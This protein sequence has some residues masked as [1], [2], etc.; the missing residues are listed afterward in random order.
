MS[1]PS[2]AFSKL[3]GSRQSEGQYRRDKILNVL[4]KE[5]GSRGLMSLA[6]V[7]DDQGYPKRAEEAYQKVIEK[8]KETPEQK[9]EVLWFCQVK[10]SSILRQ[11]GRYVGAEDQCRSFLKLSTKATGP[12]SRLSLQTAGDL[13]LVLRDQ[14]KF[15]S[16]LTEIYRTLHNETCSPYQD[17]THVRL[18]TIFAIILRDFG[19]YDMSLFLIRNALRVSGALPDLGN[20][21]PFTLDLASELS[22]I[23]TERGIH[24]LAEE[25]AR[26][27][28]DGFA[29]TFGTD[30]PQSLKAASRLANAIRFN[31]RLEDAA[32]L[33]ERTLKAQ[34]LQLGSTHPD[35]IPTKCGLAAVYA[36][37]ARFR[38]SVS[39]LRA[40]LA[41]QNELLSQ[42]PHPDTDWTVQALG[43][44]RELQKALSSDST[45]ESEMVEESRRMKDFFKKPFRKDERS[46][47]L[48][49]ALTFSK[50]DTEDVRSPSDLQWLLSAH[51]VST[52]DRNLRS[53]SLDTGSV[54]GIY[55]T[56]LHVASFV[57]DLKLV[58]RLLES[59]MDINVKGGI[60]E[61]PLCAA[62]YRGHINIVTFLLEH[63]VNVND[64]GS[65]GFCAPQL[66]LSMDH[67]DLAGTLLE[68]GA[69]YEVTDHWYG[70]ALHE[71][72]MTGQES[73]VNLLLEAKAEPDV[74]TG[75]FGT[76]LGAAAWNGNLAIV[77][78]LI[79]KGA[80]V[81]ARPRGR[82]ALDIAASRGH[83]VIMEALIREAD[84]GALN[85]KHKSDTLESKSL[86]PDIPIIE[87]SKPTEQSEA[88][89]QK[90]L[91]HL[92]PIKPQ[93]QRQP[94]QLS[95]KS[96][97]AGKTGAENWQA[98][99]TRS[100][101]GRA[102]KKVISASKSLISSSSNW[103]GR[104]RSDMPPKRSDPQLKV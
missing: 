94:D 97:K 38:D 80:N 88:T 68:A 89:L 49:D 87:D 52:D 65:Y 3:P 57:G 39:I 100:K 26:R 104:V 84:I 8:I 67:N 48:Y 77:E 32:Q 99:K 19:H 10:I 5:D 85:P 98:R 74:P 7:L 31:E 51:D 54:S 27:A 37:E 61:T 23:L 102:A 9:D 78:T 36:L 46:L 60:F 96:S 30:H 93:I 95:T 73:M 42:K 70:N 53:S 45:S 25:F 33:F 55:G 50:E 76:A 63:N 28:L 34:E 64:N 29:K 58:R 79:E 66:A 82:T 18:V 35:T 69:N 62:S 12:P 81:N 44:I 40:T 103:I 59:G 43:R 101:L 6:F 15:D 90:P 41:Q 2:K 13:A 47:H 83:K 1:R 86:E 21:H 56:T 72:S 71:A 75:I 92:E 4:Q 17:D 22:Q 11:S 16:A 20:D 24:H 14:G 91:K